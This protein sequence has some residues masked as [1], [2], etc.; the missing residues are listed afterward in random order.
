M[1]FFVFHIFRIFS[2]HRASKG[3]YHHFLILGADSQHMFFYVLFCGAL[4]FW[5][6][7]LKDENV[8]QAFM[9]MRLHKVRPMLV[10]AVLVRGL[11]HLA[12]TPTG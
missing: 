11:P 2:L 8:H 3:P 5:R 4:L 7:L 6:L 12:T 10:L 1:H 9:L